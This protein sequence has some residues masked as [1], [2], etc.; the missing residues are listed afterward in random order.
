[1]TMLDSIIRRK[2][3][4]LTEVVRQLQEAMRAKDHAAEIVSAA[5]G[6]H[7]DSQQYLD[8]V[9]LSEESLCVQRLASAKAGESRADQQ[10]ARARADYREIAETVQRFEQ[11]FA[12]LSKD[13][14]KLDEKR[15]E[16]SKEAQ[17]QALH[18]EWHQLDEWVTA[19]HGSRDSALE[20][21]ADE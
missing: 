8:Q 6:E 17:A 11:R 4:L 13:V 1:M 5:E 3:L 14:E 21:R 15:I 18:A 10:L 9:L 2:R 16:R 19:R 12:R 20:R 7:R